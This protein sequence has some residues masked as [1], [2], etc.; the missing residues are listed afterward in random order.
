[1]RQR[2][3]HCL[4]YKMTMENEVSIN[5]ETTCDGIAYHAI[6]IENAVLAEAT[7]T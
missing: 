5:I 3:H 2:V 1:M 7:Y 4:H 6:C